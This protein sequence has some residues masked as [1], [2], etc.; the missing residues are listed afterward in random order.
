VVSRHVL[1]GGAGWV[2]I[3]PRLGWSMEGDTAGGEAVAESPDEVIW[4]LKWTIRS[5]TKG[6]S[7]GS[8]VYRQKKRRFKKNLTFKLYLSIIFV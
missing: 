5:G 7:Y 1:F 6:K 8:V 4:R 3:Y 2:D